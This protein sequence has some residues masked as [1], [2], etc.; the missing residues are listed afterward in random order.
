LF[1]Q[2]EVTADSFSRP[3]GYMRIQVFLGMGAAVHLIVIWV[4]LAAR[5]KKAMNEKK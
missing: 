1:T 4:P 5:I 3:D 2:R